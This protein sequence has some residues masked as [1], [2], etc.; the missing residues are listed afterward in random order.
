P[1]SL[2]GKIIFTLFPHQTVFE[3]GIN[4]INF[5]KNKN[6]KKYLLI[7][8]METAINIF[9]D[10]QAKKND[11][12][13]IVGLGSVGLLTAYFFKLNGYNNL[14]VSDVNL[15]KKSIAKKLNLNFIHY[16]KINHLDCIINTTSDY[17]VLNNSFTKL[18]LDGKI[19]EASW[20]GQRIGKLNLGNDF[21]SKRLKIISSQVSNIPVHMQKTQSYKSRLKI[22]I[23]SLTD[24]KL[25]F[26]INSNS[27]FENLEKDYISILNDKNIIMHA[28]KY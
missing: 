2:T 1:K 10:S 14:Y 25:I 15:S 6:K 9:W 3:I 8:N 12:I 27:R 13:L 17:N 23:S 24:D 20:Y 18:N 19:I 21:H 4:N 5:I 16:N 7:A 28:V 26:L 22:A 11:R